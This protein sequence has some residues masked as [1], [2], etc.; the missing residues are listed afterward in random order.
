MIASSASATAVPRSLC[1]CTERH[2][3][4]RREN[5]RLIHSIWSAYTLGVDRSTVHGRLKMISRP[6]SGCQRPETASHTSM[7]KSSSV[8]TKISGEYS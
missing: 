6:A 1:V 4:S 5:C 3:C 7:A 2:T 8:S